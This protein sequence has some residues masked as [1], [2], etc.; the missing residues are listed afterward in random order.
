MGDGF[1]PL[2]PS[3]RLWETC[4]GRGQTDKQDADI[5]TTRP[6]RPKGRFG[7]KIIIYL[8]CIM[9]TSISRTPESS[10]RFHMRKYMQSQIKAQI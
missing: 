1:A 5:E 6:K 9:F 3:M 7:E 10:K 2:G 8:M 4:M